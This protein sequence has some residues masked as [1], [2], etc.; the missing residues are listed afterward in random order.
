MTSPRDWARIAVVGALTSIGLTGDVGSGKSAVLAWLAG[1]GAAT[2]DAD[3][4]VHAL[5]ATDPAVVAAVAARFGPAVRAGDGVDRGA[6][7]DVVFRDG[8]A[9]ADLEAIVHPPALAAARAWLAGVTADVAAIEAVKLVESGLHRSLDRLW[10]VVCD[11]ATR[12]RRLEARGGSAPEAERR[13]AAGAPYAPR[14]ALADEVIDNSGPWAATERQLDA[15]WL[16]LASR[17]ATGAVPD[18]GPPEGEEPA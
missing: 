16:R 13:M 4:A 2:L 11:P 10:L 3:A 7:A 15:A 5:L 17:R 14:L 9:L 1:R 18:S 12:R 6:L 8:S